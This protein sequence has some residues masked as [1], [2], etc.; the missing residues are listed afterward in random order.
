MAEAIDSNTLEVVN[1][2]IY[3]TTSNENHATS[4]NS[5]SLMVDGLFHFHLSLYRCIDPKLLVSLTQILSVK[6]YTTHC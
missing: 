6:N 5:L 4:K 1:A 3:D 2:A